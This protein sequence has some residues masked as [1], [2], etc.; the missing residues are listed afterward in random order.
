[1]TN[2]PLLDPRTHELVAIGAS[3]AGNCLPCLRYH[4]AEARKAG[5]S[6]EEIQEAIGISKMVKQRPLDDIARLASELIE[7]EQESI[8]S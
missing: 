6:I 7:R 3:I 8:S 2:N 4:F 1:M 5:C